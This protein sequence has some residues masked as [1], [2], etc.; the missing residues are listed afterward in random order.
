MIRIGLC[1][2]NPS[3]GDI[4]GNYERIKSSIASARK[5]DVELLLFPELSLTGYPPEDLLLQPH[6]SEHAAE[7][8]TRLASEISDIVVVLGFPYLLENK[9]F[10]SA[11]VICRG[12]IINIYSKHRL[13]NY[14]VFDEQRYFES[15]NKSSVLVLNDARIGI[16]ICEDVWHPGGPPEWATTE[17]GAEILVNLSASPYHRAKGQEREQLFSARAV[18]YNCFLA[19]CNTVGGQDELVFDGHSFIVD[20]TGTVIIRG[21]Q[22]EEDLVV[23]DLDHTEATQKRVPDARWEN[24]I[25]TDSKRVS[26]IPLPR[27]QSKD[28]KPFP[29]KLSSLLTSEAEVY[30][31]LVVGTSDYFR[32]NNFNHAVLGLSGGIDSALALVIAVDALGPEAVS[33]V[34]LPSRFTAEV[35]RIDAKELTERLGV[36]LLEIPIEPLVTE[37]ETALNQVFKDTQPNVAEENLQARIRGNLLMA[38]SN[39]FNWLVLTTGNKSELSVGYATLYGDMAGGF[40]VLKDVFKTWVYR[41][42]LWKNQPTEVIPI[43]II[44]KPPSAE[45]R[46]DQ[47][48]SDSLPEYDV[49][50]SILTAYV[51]NDQSARSIE[52]MGHDRSTVNHVLTLVDRA[53]YKRRQAPPGVRISTRAFGKDRRL[54]IS[55]GSSRLN[56]V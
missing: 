54:P 6:F 4:E 37:Y 8:M 14:A 48:D 34:S 41:L 39:K 24:G 38:L 50:D 3:V 17:G 46:P 23:A 40:S 30:Q 21:K 2:T 15:G 18:E 10:N 16:T 43:N 13:P 47:L 53:E 45:L 22:F 55:N 12:E 7:V 26:I 44:N 28:V 33:A 51:E 42:C 11:A 1:Q 27:T 25:S 31:A 29:K 36:H 56:S 35:N 32:K 5:D 49:L 9:L 20:P 19:F 52:E